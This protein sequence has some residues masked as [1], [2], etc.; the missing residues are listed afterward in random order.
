MSEIKLL[1]SHLG[2]L[3]LF[4]LCQTLLALQLRFQRRAHSTWPQVLCFHLLCASAVHHANCLGWTAI[5]FCFPATMLTVSAQSQH[6]T[7][8]PKKIINFK[9][10]IK[11]SH[12]AWFLWHQLSDR[13]EKNLKLQQNNIQSQMQYSHLLLASTGKFKI[14]QDL[15]N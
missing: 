1:I 3:L 15:M 11:S 2:L 10:C 8:F 14:F 12:T 6:C 5:P 13:M 7:L 4:S 9:G